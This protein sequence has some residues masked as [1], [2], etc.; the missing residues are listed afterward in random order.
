MFK[1]KKKK[2]SP[3]F[4]Q[5]FQNIP[6]TFPPKFPNFPNGLNGPQVFGCKKKSPT[7]VGTSDKAENKCS[8]RRVRVNFDHEAWSGGSRSRSVG[9]PWIRFGEGFVRIL[10]T[11]PWKGWYVNPPAVFLVHISKIWWVYY[12]KRSKPEFFGTLSPE[13]L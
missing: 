4:G 3:K 8:P 1:L 10:E 6:P 12:C 13:C 9:H 2:H 11:W 5:S 7:S